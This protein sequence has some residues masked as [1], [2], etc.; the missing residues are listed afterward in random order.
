MEGSVISSAK[1]TG[2]ILVYKNKLRTSMEQYFFIFMP[3]FVIWLNIPTKEVEITLK[4][5]LNQGNVLLLSLRNHT[6]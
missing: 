5:M 3:P 1:T 4:L 2:T 6:F